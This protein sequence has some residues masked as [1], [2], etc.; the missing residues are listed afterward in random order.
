MPFVDFA[1]LK[2]RVR[3]ENVAAML[4]LDIKPRGAQLRAPC[5]A[6]RSGGERALVITPAKQVFYCFG[7]RSGGDL[8][9]LVAHVRGCGANEAATLIAQHFGTGTSTVPGTE[10]VPATV[11]PARAIGHRVQRLR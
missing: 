1:A 2:S 4:A 6:C 10:P 3:I 5:P 8:I 9:A 7:A 11:P